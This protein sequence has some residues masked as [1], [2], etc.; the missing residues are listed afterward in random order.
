MAAVSDFA[1]PD[2]L[3][4]HPLAAVALNSAPPGTP[5][6]GLWGMALNRTQLTELLGL[7]R[8]LVDRSVGV[9]DVVERMHRTIQEV[10]GPFGA[11]VHAATRGLTGVVY[12]CIRGGMKL[13]GHGLDF[14]I[15]VADGLLPAAASTPE[16]EEFASILNGIFGDHLARTANP[17]AIEMGLRHEGT[18]LGPDDLAAFRSSV[19]RRKLLV[20]VH[21]LCMSDQQWSPGGRGL[22]TALA[23]ELGYVPLYLR[24]NSGLPIA[25]NGRRFAALLEQL[26]PRRPRELDEFVIVGHSMGGLVA[27]SACSVA[28]ARGHEWLKSLD[29]LVFLATPHGGAPLERVGSVLDFVLGVTPYSAPFVRLGQARSAGIKDLRLG[30]ITSAKH[31]FVPLPRGVACYT[32]AATL[33]ARRSP[34][35]DRL[36]GD[37]LVPLHS[38]LGRGR[39]AAH[40]LQFAPERRW[41]GYEMGH[42]ELLHR[43]E[44]RDQLRAW[45]GE[46]VREPSRGREPRNDARRGASAGVAS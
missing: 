35:G 46:K 43:P 19:A 13:A 8:M 10:P 45:L 20:M 36:V 33:A 5:S 26:I 37:G 1:P 32:M 16:R 7:G 41:I 34:L 23:E 9:V 31:R 28:A 12:R 24:Y 27:R 14:S 6:V 18:V 15:G 21:G 2:S 30:T 25:E 42:L 11:P 29:R 39:D 3:P 4:A 22:G 44:A 17:L 38:A 40:T